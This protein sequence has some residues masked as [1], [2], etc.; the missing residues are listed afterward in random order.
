MCGGRGR[1]GRTRRS[2]YRATSSVFQE[3]RWTCQVPRANAVMGMIAGQARLAIGLRF[4]RSMCTKDDET[5]AMSPS[6]AD[7]YCWA[8]E[9]GYP[10]LVVGR[11][12]IL[13]GLPLEW[14]LWCLSFR[15]RLQCTVKGF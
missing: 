11:L 7:E 12:G 1:E 13:A 4:R 9:D 5:R 6:G 10:C 3:R 14:R 2:S 15:E 8:V